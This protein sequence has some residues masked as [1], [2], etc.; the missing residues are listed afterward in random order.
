MARFPRKLLLLG[1]LTALVAAPTPLHTSHAAPKTLCDVF[2]DK[3]ARPTSVLQNDE[4]EI[5]LT[6]EGHCPAGTGGHVADI[7]L[8]IDRSASMGD[9]GSFAPAIQAAGEFLKLIDFKNQQ[10]ALVTFATENFTSPEAMVNQPLTSDGAA[11]SASLAAIPPPLPV[12]IWTN[13]TAAIHTAQEELT[14]ERH[15]PGAEPV[16]VMLTDGG[17][18]A[19]LARSPLAEAQDAKTAG[20]Q[21]IT[22]GLGT[23]AAAANTLRQIASAPELYYEAPTV[24]QL[25]DVYRAIA[26]QITTGGGLTNLEISDLLTSDV[27]YVDGSAVPAPT[28]VGAGQ[29]KWSVAAL[30]ANG[31]AAR[32]RVKALTVGTYPTNKLAYVDYDDADGSVASATFPQPVITVRAPGANGLFLPILLRDYCPPQRPFDVALVID[33]SSSM[34]GEKLASTRVA[35]GEFLDLLTMPPSR[36]AV[37]AFN[38]D[39]TVVQALTTD[40]G[41]AASALDKLPRGDGTRIDK[42]LDAARLELTGPNHDPKHASVI[43]LLTDGQQT[44]ADPQLARNAAAAARRAGITV[45]TIGI[46]PDAA[47]SLLIEIAGDP[48]RY[49]H[50]PGT[51]EL[52][53]IYR[54][55]A[56]GLPCNIH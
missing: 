9:S 5:T 40:R 15:R 16:L 50:A 49:Y 7:V 39:A 22:I 44:G 26:G 1:C 41:A 6:V 51:A 3:T 23:D 8:A 52:L 27:A 14:S 35:A 19:L 12:T 11:V 53:Q 30:A 13:L 29:L 36:A 48:A 43:V 10:V 21:I 42:A 55:I 56:G 24:T 46:G 17:H 34:A 38:A 2:V 31:W 18:N 45:Y 47:E 20:T 33:T 25:A 32:Y 54:D 28:S 37:V 4:V